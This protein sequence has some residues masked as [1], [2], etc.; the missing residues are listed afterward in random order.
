MYKPVECINLAS[1]F[2]ES[3]KTSKLTSKVSNKL[4]A[5]SAGKISIGHNDSCDTFTDLSQLR[6]K[7][8]NRLIIEHLNIN[9]KSGKFDQLKTLIEKNID[10]LIFTETKIDASFPNSQ[11][12]IDG[13]SSPFRYD[14]NRFGGEM[15][16][17]IFGMIFCVKN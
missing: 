10:V 12:I 17:S 16:L 4:N 2:S 11:F 6:I 8:V 7:N 9:T 5:K 15:F 1:E 13:Y 14:R 3:I